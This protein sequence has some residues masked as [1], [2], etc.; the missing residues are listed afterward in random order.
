MGVA[1]VAAFA[2][3]LAVDLAPLQRPRAEISLQLDAEALAE[4]FREGV[5]WHGLYRAGDKVGFVRLERRRRG[6]GFRLEQL[7]VL[8]GLGDHDTELHVQTDL[9]AS[10]SL[11]AF[12]ASTRAPL[13]ARVAGRWVGDA[14][15]IEVEGI[16]G[17]P[18]RRIPL[19]EP[20][21][22]DFS[23]APLAARSDLAVGDRFTFT[24]FD[25]MTLA[26]REGTVEMLGREPVDVLGERVDA[27]HL[28]QE[29]AGQTL[30]L[31]INPLGEVLRE[32]M[33]TGLLAVREAEAEAT[34]EA[35]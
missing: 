24:H 31:W 26:S 32:Q 17:L 20:P 6:D 14:L 29:I 16:P 30:E 22:F 3:V 9:D 34:W 28:R 23:L 21:T 2:V 15:E 4:G 33:P 10:F 13:E 12:V 18:A 5:E 8:R 35:R 7:T 25:P 19:P 11:V 27:L 1:A